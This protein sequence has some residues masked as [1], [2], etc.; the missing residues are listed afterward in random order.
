MNGGAASNYA[1]GMDTY[2]CV[3]SIDLPPQCRAGRTGNKTLSQCNAE[4]NTP[5][6]TP[7]HLPTPPVPTPHHLPTP[8]CSDVSPCWGCLL[9]PGQQ[10][11]CEANFPTTNPKSKNDCLASC[12]MVPTPAP[13]PC[14]DTAPCWGCNRLSAFPQCEAQYMYGKQTHQQCLET[15]K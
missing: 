8:A 7:R 10:P 15:C 3:K 11:K 5:P 14:T 9:I 1:S 2:T 13:A 6:P 12:H 4:C